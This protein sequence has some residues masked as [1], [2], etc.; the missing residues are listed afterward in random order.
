MYKC[1]QLNKLNEYLNF[2]GVKHEDASTHHDPIIL[3]GQYKDFSMERIYIHIGKKQYSCINGQ[4]SYGYEQG[5]IETMGFED[6]KGDVT[7][8][9]TAEEVIKKLRKE[10]IKSCY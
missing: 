3:F 8:Y 1:K 6:D 4:G 5:L 7:G 2:I 9:Q 10:I